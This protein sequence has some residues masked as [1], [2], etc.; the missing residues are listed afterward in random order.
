MQWRN[1]MDKIENHISL[2]VV[3]EVAPLLRK[4]EEAEKAAAALRQQAEKTAAVKRQDFINAAHGRQSLW[5]VTA[6]GVWRNTNNGGSATIVWNVIASSSEEA[7]TSS[8]RGA[9]SVIISE[10][11]NR[12]DWEVSR[13]VCP[14]ALMK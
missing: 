9:K 2:L 1:E 12:F 7:M 8:P 13:S 4:A 5:R 14:S 6:E 10:V 3:Q 11:G